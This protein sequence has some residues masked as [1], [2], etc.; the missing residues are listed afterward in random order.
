MEDFPRIVEA[1][2]SRCGILDSIQRV[3]QD[4]GSGTH[5]LAPR[6]VVVQAVA[7]KA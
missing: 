7:E 5:A 4:V 2:Y 1:H 3:L 6:F